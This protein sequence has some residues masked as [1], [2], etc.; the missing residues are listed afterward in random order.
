MTEIVLVTGCSTGIGLATAEYL[1]STQPNNQIYA[2]MR[3]PSCAGGK[4]L[5]ALQ[6]TNLHILSLDVNSAADCKR[7]VAAVAASA[8]HPIT[9][10]VNNAG[11]GASL[12]PTEEMAEDAFRAVMET[13]YFGVLRLMQLVL[14]EMRVRGK[15]CIVN[16][17]S[18]AGR[19]ATI[20][21]GGYCASKFAVEALS[22]SLSQE[23]AQFG[24]RVKI[25]E[26]GVVVTPILT[27]SPGK[28]T[29][30]VERQ[31][32]SKE[33]PYRSASR[34]INNWYNAGAALNQQPSMVAKV[35]ADAMADTSHK[36]RFLAGADAKKIVTG[37]AKMSD[38]QWLEQGNAQLQQSPEAA[39]EWWRKNFDMN[40]KPGFRIQK[41]KL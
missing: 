24:I 37:R 29:S 12:L 8:G 30:G 22:E 36:L 40:V 16:V 2:T 34:Y 4:H 25:V 26:P 20:C 38:E 1:A 18:V 10:L 39:R 7:V 27:K 13:N 35:I 14:P 41:S 28:G 32:M 17:S 3:N 21:Q 15:G 11:V 6:H 9:C 19:I 31:T 33:S 5:S 23:V